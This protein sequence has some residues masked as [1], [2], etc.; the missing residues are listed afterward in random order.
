MDN[1]KKI[2]LD[3][4]GG[5][6]GWSK[7]YKDAGY[8]VRVITL[9]DYDVFTYKPPREIYGILAAPPCTMFSRARTTAKTPRDFKGAIEVVSACLRII[10]EAQYENRFGLKFWAMENPAGHLQR[11]M[12]KPPFKFHPYDFGDRHSKHTFIWGNFNEPKK[13]P[14]KLSKKELLQSRNNTRPLPLIPREYKR[15]ETMNPIQ[16]R[17]SITPQG[18]AKAF[19]RANQ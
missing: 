10:W 9:P 2:I 13:R 19:F 18:F 8:D 7:P 3:L 5:T 15:D 17:R 14:V 4:C 11:F 1:R 12:G 16:I 6:G